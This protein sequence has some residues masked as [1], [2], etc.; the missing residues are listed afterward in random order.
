MLK[1]FTKKI[2]AI[3]WT[4]SGNLL[5]HLEWQICTQLEESKEKKIKQETCASIQQRAVQPRAGFS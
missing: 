2:E 5:K 1:Q 4:L 3:S